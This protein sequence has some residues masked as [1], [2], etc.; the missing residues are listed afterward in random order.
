[1]LDPRTESEMTQPRLRRFFAEW[2]V[3]V[4]EEI[5]VDT[6]SYDTRRNQ[7]VPLVRHFNPRHPLTESL[8]GL[9]ESLPLTAT[10]AVF[11]IPEAPSVFQYT[12]LLFTSERAWMIDFAAYM[13]AARDRSVTPGE[14]M[15]ALPLGIAMEP[16]AGLGSS[17]PLPRMV[18]L[19]DSDFLTDPQLGQVQINLGYM[20]MN[21]LTRSDDVLDIPPREV[22]TTPLT[23]TPRQRNAVAILCVV[24]VPVSILLG[25][26]GHTAIR[27]RKR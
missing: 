5:V 13:Q 14:R 1:M 8:Q 25:G 6:G 16:A 10:A 15:S 26:L 19:G 20:V 3:G 18:V 27:R 17:A 22:E 21:W 12:D 24:I 7:F 11:Q 23:L 2:G 9:G 4:S